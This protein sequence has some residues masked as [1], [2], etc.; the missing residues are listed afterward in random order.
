M[1]AFAWLTPASL[2]VIRKGW[3]LNPR[4]NNIHLPDFESGAVPS[5]ATF[6]NVVF[7]RCL[8]SNDNVAQNTMR[9][10]GFE[11]SRPY[12]AHAPE[13]C[14]SAVPPP[15]QGTLLLYPFSQKRQM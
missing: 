13:A 15:P 10:K 14:V 2:F 11:P 1:A 5:W 9:K 6:P 8:I 4:V 7:K 12:W 3:D